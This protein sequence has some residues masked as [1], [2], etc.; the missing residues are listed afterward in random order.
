MRQSIFAIVIAITSLGAF[1]TES[2]SLKGYTI[3]QKMQDCPKGWERFSQQ[4][5]GSRLCT[6]NRAT[7][8]GVEA[9]YLIIRI[10][11]GEIINVGVSLVQVNNNDKSKAISALMEKFGLPASINEKDDFCSWLQGTNYLIYSKGM[12]VLGDKIKTA[13]LEAAKNSVFEKDM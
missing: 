3:A 1:A 10:F 2:L 11:H 4:A 9:D 6:V 8:A 12:I 13:E 7:F 5:D